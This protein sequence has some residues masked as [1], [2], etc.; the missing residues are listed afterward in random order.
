MDLV[1]AADLGHLGAGES[2]QVPKGWF[3]RES[4]PE[5]SWLDHWLQKNYGVFTLKRK[6][7]KEY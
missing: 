1:P 3:Q 2:I 4:D 6:D 5:V 7:D